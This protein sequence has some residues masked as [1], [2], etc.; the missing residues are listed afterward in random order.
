MKLFRDVW[1]VIRDFLN[2]ASWTHFVRRCK[3][4]R[5]TGPTIDAAIATVGAGTAGRSEDGAQP[6]DTTSLERRQ[7]IRLPT[8][9]TIA[10]QRPVR[11]E[12]R[13]GCPPY[14]TQRLQHLLTFDGRIHFLCFRLVLE[15]ED[16]SLS[17]SP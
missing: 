7:A 14:S 13:G 17:G 8:G 4:R 15:L 2:S 9:A 12:R 16:S 3:T 5:R 10:Q 11:R 6:P 1:F